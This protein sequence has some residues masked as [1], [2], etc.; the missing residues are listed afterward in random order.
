[1]WSVEG[2]GRGGEGGL[3]TMLME[4]LSRVCSFCQTL[5]S[6]RATSTT[7]STQSKHT[8]SAPELITRQI[9]DAPASLP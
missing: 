9:A 8:T 7:R 4:G 2:G 1:M 6:T 5:V 3:A